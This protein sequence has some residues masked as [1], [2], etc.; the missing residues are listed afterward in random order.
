MSPVNLSV[1]WRLQ[2]LFPEAGELPASEAI[3]DIRK[4]TKGGGKE[5]FSSKLIQDAVTR[6]LEIIGEAVRQLRPQ[7]IAKTLKV[8]M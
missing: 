6:K 3:A 4:H 1:G 5:F 8:L 7:T 2:D